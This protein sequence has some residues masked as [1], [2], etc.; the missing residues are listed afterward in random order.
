MKTPPNARQRHLVLMRAS[1]VHSFMRSSL[2]A[3]RV[4]ELSWMGR[5]ASFALPSALLM[6]GVHLAMGA[7]S[8]GTRPSNEAIAAVGKITKSLGIEPQ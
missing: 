1:T 5:Q 8:M 6:R 7:T 4:A 3:T 2:N